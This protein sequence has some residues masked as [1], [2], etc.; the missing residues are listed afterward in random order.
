MRLSEIKLTQGV[1]Y[2]NHP[3]VL[4]GDKVLGSE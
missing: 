2:N 4:G 3:T 1:D